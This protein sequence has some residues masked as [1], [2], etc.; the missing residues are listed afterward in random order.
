MSKPKCPKCGRKYVIG[1][2]GNI[3]G[4]E[5]CTSKKQQPIIEES[6]HWNPDVSDSTAPSVVIRFYDSDATTS[7]NWTVGCYTTTSGWNNKEGLYIDV[8]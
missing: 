8:N 2:S 6:A 5:K 3:F 1:R 7:E 4:C